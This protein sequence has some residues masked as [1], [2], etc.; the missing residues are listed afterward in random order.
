MLLF[1]SRQ[2]ASQSRKAAVSN[3]QVEFLALLPSEN[4]F[5]GFGADAWILGSV[6]HLVTFRRVQKIISNLGPSVNL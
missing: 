5:L 6:H 2:L 4:S 1:P 3:T